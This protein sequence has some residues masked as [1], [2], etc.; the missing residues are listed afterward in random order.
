MTTGQYIRR[1]TNF[2]WFTGF[3]L[4]KLPSLWWYGIKIGVMDSRQ[5][6]VKVPHSYRTKNPFGSIYFGALMCAGELSTGLLC[7]A[8]SIEK[9]RFSML[10][11]SVSGQFVKKA[12][13]TIIFKCDGGEMLKEELS[14]LKNTG[15]KTSVSLLAIGYDQTN[16]IVAEFTFQW[17]FKKLT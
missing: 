13:G 16:N 12:R 5:C 1:V 17:S 7:Q 15:D 3:A 4:T 10:V 6:H 11:T 9:G 8:H 2:W 14:V